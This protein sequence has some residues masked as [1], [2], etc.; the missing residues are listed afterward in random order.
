MPDP[1]PRR[2]PSG[3]RSAS[4]R[5]CSLIC[6]LLCTGAAA[7]V[8]KIIFDTDMD[9]DCDDLGALALLHALADKGECEILATVVSSKNPHSPACVDVVNTYYGRP[10]LPIGQPKG[11]GAQ[12]PSKYA[13]P[14]AETPADNPVRVGYGLWFGGQA[15]SRHVADPTTVLYAVR[16]LS[17]Y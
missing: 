4:L 12:K 1:A 8:P 6:V 3:L 2:T 5:L 16:G 10:D 15:G 14:L 13:K 9:S 11:A 7:P 17:D